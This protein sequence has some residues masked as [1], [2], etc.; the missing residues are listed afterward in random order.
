MFVR[1]RFQ[2]GSLRLRKRERGSD[3]WEFRYYETNPEGKGIRQSVRGDAYKF[4]GYVIHLLYATE[5]WIG[6]KRIWKIP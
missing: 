4:R 1:I 3:V 2:Y 5:V 6:Q